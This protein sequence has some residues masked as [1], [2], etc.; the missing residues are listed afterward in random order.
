MFDQID[1][2]KKKSEEAQ[3]MK[4]KK[5]KAGKKPKVQDIESTVLSAQDE[6][7]PSS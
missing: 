1:E 4:K 3:K 5:K 2:I 7:N 6:Q